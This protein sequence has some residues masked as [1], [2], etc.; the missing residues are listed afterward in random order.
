MQTSHIS[1]A[2][3]YV[4]STWEREQIIEAEWEERLR[5][6]IAKKCQEIQCP[7]YAING[8][9]DHVH[10]LLR[11]SDKL[12]IAQVAQLSKGSSSHL[13]N[14]EFNLAKSF[15]WQGSY[16]ASCVEVE[17][18]DRVRIYIYNQKQHHENGSTIPNRECSGN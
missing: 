16:G 12:A 13:I 4:W 11:L 5:A 17:N 2:I 7:A 14:H 8:M 9:P 10:V 6:A 15:R 1:V 3:H 18:I